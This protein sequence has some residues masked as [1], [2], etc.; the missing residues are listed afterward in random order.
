MWRVPAREVPTK[1]VGIHLGRYQYLQVPLVEQ[2]P[3][4]PPV[5]LRV[6]LHPRDDFEP[7][8]APGVNSDHMD[9]RL[10]QR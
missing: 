6:V 2:H 5:D 9:C 10:S 8:S 4:I 1:R 3:R 7:C